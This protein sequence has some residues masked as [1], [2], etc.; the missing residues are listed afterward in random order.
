VSSSGGG[1]GDDQ[2][3]ASHV[4]HK[5][6][7]V[8]TYH[9]LHTQW[10]KTDDKVHAIYG[11]RINKYFEHH[12]VQAR[13]VVIPGEEANKRQK[14]VDEIHEQLTV[15]GLRRREPVMAIGGG[16]ILDIVGMAANLY[17][18]GVPYIR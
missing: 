18:R 15:F 7:P 8:M 11:D 4:P 5:G 12:G 13:V 2:T 10:Y 6:V 14:A 16:V 17:R 1:G 9:L 3:F